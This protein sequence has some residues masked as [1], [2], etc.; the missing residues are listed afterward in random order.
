MKKFGKKNVRVAY[1]HF[2]L[3]FHP[4]AKLAAE[5]SMAAHAQG[6]FWLYYHK[7]FA[8]QEHLDKA[9]LLRLA[10]EL[11]LDMPKFKKALDTH[12]YK[13]IVEQDLQFASQLGVSGTPSFFINGMP[14]NDNDT[15]DGVGNE[16][17][18]RANALLKKGIKPTHL[19]DELIKGG[20]VKP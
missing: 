15:M 16:A 13:K 2:P 14:V 17:L 5:A 20:R 8:N 4:Q 1:R 19:Y 3:P 6:K 11:K 12:Q 7:L 18:K 9:G 10:K